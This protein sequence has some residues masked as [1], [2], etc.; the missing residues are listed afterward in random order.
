[1]GKERTVRTQWLGLHQCREKVLVQDGV[2]KREIICGE[3]Y[4]KVLTK[5]SKRVRVVCIGCGATCKGKAARLA[6]GF[7]RRPS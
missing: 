5:G 6:P 3:V 4:R 7:P 2:R 1:M